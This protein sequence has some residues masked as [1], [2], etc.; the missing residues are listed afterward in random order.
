MDSHLLQTYSGC[1]REPSLC[2]YPET[3]QLGI[4]ITTQSTIDHQQNK[5]DENYPMQDARHPR[6]LF[7]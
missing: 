3:K 7:Q 4:R 1:H 5:I 6:T 2:H